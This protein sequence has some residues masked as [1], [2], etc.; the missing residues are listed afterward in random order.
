M[1][2]REIVVLSGKG[3][4]GKTSLAAAFATFSRGIVVADCDVDAANL[5]LLLSPRVLETGAFSG[6]FEASIRQADCSRCG[7]CAELCRFGSVSEMGGAFRIADCEGCGVCVGFC[8]NGAID[9]NASDTGAWMVCES[10]VGPMVHARLRP[11]AEN[12]G[13][14]A[15]LVKDKARGLAVLHGADIVL[16]DGPPGIGCPAIASLAGA[17]AA[18]VVAEPTPS[19]LHD[20]E[21]ILDLA[22]HFS[23]PSRVLVNKCDLNP[24]LADRIESLALRKGCFLAGR[25]PYAMEFTRSQMA[26]QPLP[27]LFPGSDIARRIEKIWKETQSWLRK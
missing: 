9:W 23:V 27:L 6:G 13:K 24:E 20:L 7:L 11:G 15:S 3:G 4:T 10:S 1:T 26:A 12:S 18:L 8:P 17:H 19:G 2:A 25:I 16:V 22:G 14:L 21:R 5:H